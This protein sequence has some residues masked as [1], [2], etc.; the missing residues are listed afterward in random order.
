MLT[1]VPQLTL[2]RKN[3]WVEVFCARVC[4]YAT[5]TGCLAQSARSYNVNLQDPHCSIPRGILGSLPG[6]ALTNKG[7]AEHPTAGLLCQAYSVLKALDC[8]AALRLIEKSY[9]LK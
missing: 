3:Y 6:K 8:A 5:G 1:E 4:S 9:N 7:M 2:Q